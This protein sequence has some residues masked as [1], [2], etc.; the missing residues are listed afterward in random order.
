MA[1]LDLAVIGNCNVAGLVDSE[2]VLVWACFPRPDGDPVF[3]RLLDGRPPEEAADDGAFRVE[4]AGLVRREQRYI[5][6]TAVL[7]TRLYDDQGGALEIVDF[8]P[9]YRQWSRSFRPMSL[10][11]IVRPLEGTPRVRIALRPRFAYGATAPEITY[12]SN[13][14]RYVGPALAL[15]LYTDM[16]IPYVLEERS[17]LLE[18]P[19]TFIFGADESLNAPISVTGREFLDRTIDH[20]R[21]W[22][23]GLALPAEW[24]TE[25][26]RAAITLKLCSFEQTGAIVAAMTTSIP[27]FANS[28]RN[29]DYR[30]CWLRD[31][32]FVVR[33]LNRLGAITTME[34]YL[35]YVLNL[36]ADAD[37]EHLQPVYGISLERRLIEREVVSLTGYRGMGPVRV[38]NQA[39]EHLQHDVYG[40][41]ILACT[42][43]FLDLRLHAPAGIAE[44]RRLEWV[45]ERAFAVH[46]Q[47]DAG[48][49]EY[50]TRHRV[51]TTSSL[52][53]WAGLDRLA[54]IADVLGL[55]DRAAYWRDRAGVVKA[56]IEAEAWNE[57]AGTLVES[58]G[59]ESI[60]SGLLLIG[61]VG[62]CRR[63]IRDSRRQFAAWNARSAE[64]IT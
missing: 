31:A 49:W 13:H 6:N 33:A 18:E 47:P 17:F 54:R 40:N 35:R 28:G 59:G 1:G 34:E 50:R 29:W 12:G 43:A 23:H 24:Q 56:S 55:D 5:H 30:Y 51:H 2:G 3:C 32:Y 60:D 27:E 21:V 16:P 15:R 22:V 37:D 58:F 4:L 42:Q 53:C 10:V 63:T 7:S 39:Y 20:W 26:I 64:V 61:E 9:R 45:G 19:V 36:V 38:G 41:V 57:R 14:I 46:N 48:M 25:V 52:M 44:Y 62:F 11:R 8:A